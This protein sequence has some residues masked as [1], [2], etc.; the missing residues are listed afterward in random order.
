MRNIE[1]LKEN[2][3]TD[4]QLD[5]EEVIGFVILA[6]NNLGIVEEHWQH[7]VR[8][9]VLALEKTDSVIAEET[10][11]NPDYVKDG[12]IS[13]S[14]WAVAK[15]K[16]NQPIDRNEKLLLMGDDRLID[17]VITEK[18][19]VGYM[20]LAAKKLNFLHSQ[21]QYLEMEIHHLLITTES[22]QAFDA[23]LDF[24]EE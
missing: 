23:F 2:P 8:E 18:Q 24:I 5:F 14:K 16:L 11:Y 20:I 6:S 12:L 13:L 10:Y 17:I 21:I 15:A 4:N 19:A 22:K 3:L 7:L 9:M 1:I